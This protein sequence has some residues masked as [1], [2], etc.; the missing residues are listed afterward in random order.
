M[1]HPIATAIVFLI[2]GAVGLQALESATFQAPRSYDAK[3]YEADWNKNPF[4]LKTEAAAIEAVSFAKDLAIGSYYGSS[5]DPVV[6]IMN[7]TTGERIRLQQGK[8]AT[9][10]MVLKTFKHGSGRKD[11][12][13]EVTLGSETCELRYNDEYVRQAAASAGAGGMT[14]GSAGAGGVPPGSAAPGRQAIPPLPQGQQPN[15]G[16]NGRVPFTGQAVNQA[17]QGIPP[18]VVAA[19]G[20]A[21][22]AGASIP[23][24]GML[25]SGVGVKSGPIPP[26]AVKSAANITPV[27]PTITVPSRRRLVTPPAN[28]PDGTRP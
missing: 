8:P 25:S 17:A 20:A 13:A 21:G 22:A 4:T 26:R 19:P 9:N 15:P 24:P 5:E 16:G 7:T 12:V 11:A 23:L 1:S 3:R 28:T 6:V 18:A 27:P 14:P 10:G 2:T